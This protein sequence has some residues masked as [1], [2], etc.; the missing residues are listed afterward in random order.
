MGFDKRGGGRIGGG[1]GGRC[2]LWGKEGGVF[3]VGGLEF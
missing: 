1:K 3:V 2:G